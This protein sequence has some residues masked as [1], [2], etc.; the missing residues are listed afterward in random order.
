MPPPLP[1]PPDLSWAGVFSP[2]P[3]QAFRAP[4]SRAE[5]AGPYPPRRALPLS[6]VARPGPAPEPAR[7]GCGGAVHGAAAA[8]RALLWDTEGIQTGA[9]PL[10]SIAR[11]RELPGC[12]PL[13]PQDG[14]GALVGFILSLHAALLSQDGPSYVLALRGLAT[15]ATV[16]NCNSWEPQV[17]GLKTVPTAVLSPVPPSRAVVRLTYTITPV[18][19]RH[20]LL[21]MSC[22]SPG[23]ECNYLVMA[24]SERAAKVWGSPLRAWTGSLK[25]HDYQGMKAFGLKAELA[26]TRATCPS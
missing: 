14:G 1:P 19:T 12:S 16:G 8:G 6:V 15:P 26:A 25:V 20:V 24:C 5:F 22:I 4:P 13:W 11:T 9:A 18:G 10:T 23:E 2:L 7:G 21:G 3:P 17:P